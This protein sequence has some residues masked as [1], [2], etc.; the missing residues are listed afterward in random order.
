MSAAVIALFLL[1][2]AGFDVG[3]TMILS[4]YFSILTGKRL[5]NGTILPVQIVAG[6]DNMS[7]S[8]SPFLC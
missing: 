3:F 8:P 7:S 5:V 2:L 1:L 4:T 6:V